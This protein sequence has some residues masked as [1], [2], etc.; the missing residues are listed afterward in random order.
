MAG[1]KFNVQVKPLGTDNYV[2]WSILVKQLLVLQGLWSVVDPDAE[3]TE[4]EDKQQND[5]HWQSSRFIW[6]SSIYRQQVPQR[7]R[8]NFGLTL[9]P[10]FKQRV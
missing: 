3:K 6:K 4:N 5:K 2:A 7:Q 1:S 9:L 10:P 8:G